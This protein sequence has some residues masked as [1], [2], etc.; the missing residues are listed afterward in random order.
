MNATMRINIM[1]DCKLV[2]LWWDGLDLFNT[3][4]LGFEAFA[5]DVMD[6]KSIENFD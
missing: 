1:F 2:K 5:V 6:L 4:D 3:I